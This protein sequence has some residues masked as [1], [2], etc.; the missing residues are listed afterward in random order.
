MRTAIMDGES[1]EKNHSR[2]ADS[3]AQNDTMLCD[4]GVNRVRN[5]L[6]DICPPAE[7]RNPKV[8]RIANRRIHR[9][10]VSM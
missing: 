2:N 9:K 4:C 7:G 3:G 5:L 6:Y 1:N 8:M 10:P